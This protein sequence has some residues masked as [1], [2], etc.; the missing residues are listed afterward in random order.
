M[1]FRKGSR[2]G[3]YKLIRRIGR[4]GFGEVWLAERHSE[5]ITT[6]VAIKL[7]LDDKVN[8]NAIKKEANLWVQAS[9][10][11][12]V[13]PIIDARIYKKQVVIVSEY[14]DGGSVADLLQ[15]DGK[16][17]IKQA[18]DLSIGV[19]SGLE[20]LH[21][22]KIIHRDIKPGNVLLQSGTPRLVDFGISRALETSQISSVIVGTSA[23]MSP[24][25]F[26]GVR[27]VQTDIWSVGVVLYQLLT[28]ALPFPQPNL[29]ERMFAILTKEPEPLPLDIPEHLQLII[30]KSL[31]K[32]PEH[33]YQTANEMCEDLQEFRFSIPQTSVSPAVVAPPAPADVEVET[34][35]VQTE[36]PEESEVKFEDETV[37]KVR[38][39][40]PDVPPDVPKSKFLQVFLLLLLLG[41]V[42]GALA[43]IYL[44][45]PFQ[46]A[47]NA[48]NANKNA[49]L[50]SPSPTPRKTRTPANTNANANVNTTNL[51]ANSN[52]NTYPPALVGC[53]EGDSG[54][55][56]TNV[57][58]RSSARH[59][60]EDNIL[61]VWYT[62][63]EVK[64]VS[65]TKGEPRKTTG[66][67]YWYYVEV[68]DGS[69]DE[70]I[71]PT[72]CQT[73]RRG[74]MNADLVDC[75]EED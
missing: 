8:L 71:S 34:E 59:N 21:Q 32:L 57:R 47:N 10:H 75:N 35:I 4:G 70:S 22:K 29:N 20:Y 63:S 45:N 68:K 55:L 13:L 62:D 17:S 5:L 48:N 3:D 42:G 66:N 25:A 19:L 74:Y 38:P 1:S 60:P 30:K 52:A 54:Y 37:T 40:K 46:A 41:L 44:K 14:A 28:G 31:A 67:P 58:L 6:K 24:E 11:P 23:Y 2:I 43:F 16:L 51:N 72:A 26:E 61:A 27:S 36:K 12:N 65:I 15:R 33:R 73:Q 49:N 50:P 69:C 7:P 64:V 18:V 9:G 56:N 39:L 53:G